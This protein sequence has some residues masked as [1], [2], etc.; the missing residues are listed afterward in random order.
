MMELISHAALLWAWLERL[1]AWIPRFLLVAT[2]AYVIIYCTTLA[3]VATVHRHW[4]RV[5]WFRRLLY[6]QFPLALLGVVF[7]G[8]SRYHDLPWLWAVG[9]SLFSAL[10]LYLGAFLIAAL[11]MTPVVLGVS[12]YDRLRQGRTEGPSSIERRH[13]LS[14]GLAVVPTLLGRRASATASTPRTLVRECLR[15]R[16]AIPTCPPI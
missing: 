2:A 11:L 3:L 16:S 1:V 9:T 5:A 6:W 8:L 13:F 10:T 4:W 14:R 15:C 7:C 12:L